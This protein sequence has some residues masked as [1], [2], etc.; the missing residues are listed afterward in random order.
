[1]I[2]EGIRSLKRD[3]ISPLDLLTAEGEREE[4]PSV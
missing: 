4:Y 3:I 2:D 1:M